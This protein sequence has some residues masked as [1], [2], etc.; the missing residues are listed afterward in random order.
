M[1]GAIKALVNPRGE[2]NRAFDAGGV[3][4]MRMR[5]VGRAVTRS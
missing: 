5:L 4:F 1:E 2:K 3:P